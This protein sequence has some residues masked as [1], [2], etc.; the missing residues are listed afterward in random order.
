MSTSLQSWLTCSSEQNGAS[1]AFNFISRN[2]W[3]IDSELFQS[4]WMLYGL[5][6]ESNTRKKLQTKCVVLDYG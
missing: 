1:E 6:G 5:E 4:N 2:I 3:G